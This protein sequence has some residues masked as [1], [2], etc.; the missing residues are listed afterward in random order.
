MIPSMSMSASCDPGAKACSLIL[1]YPSIGM[2][3]RW[4]P[5]AGRS[6]EWPA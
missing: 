3:E 2:A 4:A 5:C 6:A 1:F